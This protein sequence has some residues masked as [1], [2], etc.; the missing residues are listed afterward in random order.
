MLQPGLSISDLWR[1]LNTLLGEIYPPEEARAVSRLVLEHL[2]YPQTNIL[3]KGEDKADEA[4]LMQINKIV[5]E[6]KQFKP[7]QYVLGEA[8]FHD[9]LFYVNEAV[10]IPRQETEELVDIIARE[11][12]DCCPVILDI[13][14][15][16]GCIAVTLAHLLPGAEVHATDFSGKAIEVA[17][18]NAR[19]NNCSIHF[20]HCDLFSVTPLPPAHKYDIIVSNPP[21]VTDSEKKLMDP[22]VL[23]HEPSTALFVPDSD[24]LLFYRRIAELTPQVLRK[25]GTVWLEINER[26]GEETAGLFRNKAFREVRVIKDLR[27][28]DRFI[29]V[30]S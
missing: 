23:D 20:H 16:S 7:V 28:K 29:K 19:K 22:Q 6:L 2:G 24:P 13:G 5:T 30:L 27:N 18:G 15:G 8:N 3:M 9:L 10:L 25:G 11:N 4:A 12:K 21:Y 14:T 17:R 1:S 26:F